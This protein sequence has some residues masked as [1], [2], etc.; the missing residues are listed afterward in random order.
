M[1][2][3]EELGGGVL[4]VAEHEALALLEK[5]TGRVLVV[6]PIGEAAVAEHPH[7]LSQSPASLFNDSGIWILVVF[8]EQGETF[9][10]LGRGIVHGKSSLVTCFGVRELEPSL[11]R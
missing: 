7:N 1:T 9:G 5:G 11:T 3:H 4:G 10:F 8:P 6:A 2:P